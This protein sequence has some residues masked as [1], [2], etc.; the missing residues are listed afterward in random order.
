MVGEGQSGDGSSRLD[1]LLSAGTLPLESHEQTRT[2]LEA[3]LCSRRRV[4]WPHLTRARVKLDRTVTHWN[5]SSSGH[6]GKTVT[7][8]SVVCIIVK[9]LC[10]TGGVRRLDQHDYAHVTESLQCPSSARDDQQLTPWEI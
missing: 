9:T 8:P 2:N 10:T 4:F 3:L 6:H 5:N 7:L 1:C